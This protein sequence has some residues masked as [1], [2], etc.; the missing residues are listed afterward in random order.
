MTTRK[1][2]APPD[3]GA[4]GRKF[5]RTTMATFEMSDVETELLIEVA[6]LLDEC[7]NLRNAVQ[8]DGVTVAGSTGQ[9]RV[10][11]ALGELRQHRLAL[12]RLLA[13]LAL[14]DVDDGSLSAPAQLRARKASETRWA[15]HNAVKAR[16][17][18]ALNGTA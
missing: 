11:P 17:E 3:L 4:R 6:R 10:H 7:E 2:A 15:A 1:P 9:P 8:T 13:Q 16:R 5:W 18:A 12:G 14:P